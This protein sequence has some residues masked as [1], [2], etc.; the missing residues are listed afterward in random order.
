MRRACQES[1][2]AMSTNELTTAVILSAVR[3]PIGRLQGA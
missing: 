2:V 1:V 3:T